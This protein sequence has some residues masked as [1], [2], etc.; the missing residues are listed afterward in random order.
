VGV[1][2][3]A[4]ASLKGGGGGGGGSGINWTDKG[5]K[6]G[7]KTSLPDGTHF[8]EDGSGW[9]VKG[10][11]I[12]ARTGASSEG[13]ERFKTRPRKGA[14]TTSEIREGIQDTRFGFRWEGLQGIRDDE[15]VTP[16]EYKSADKTYSRRASQLN[17]RIAA[18]RKRLRKINKA[19]AGK[20]TPGTR[21]RLLAEKG[22]LLSDIGG[23]Q[24]DLRS[25]TGEFQ[26]LVAPFDTDTGDAG[27][28]VSED[29]S[30]A[31]LAQAILELKESIDRQNAF[32]ESV[33]GIG[34]REA[35]KAFTD[36]ISGQI[37]GYVGQRARSAGDGTTA[38]RY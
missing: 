9:K 4:V 8:F 35:L 18:K 16:E 33:A 36:V 28:G 5:G 17:E 29:T 13:R 11:R 31:D 32:A 1:A 19:L 25:L 12:V 6:V 27:G 3:A 2:Q 37:G 21:K 15:V 34:Q 24:G 20:L 23:L 22:L 7:D 38:A 30:A 10:G 26:D 14:R